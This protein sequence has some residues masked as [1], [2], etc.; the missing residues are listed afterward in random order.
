MA[1]FYSQSHYLVMFSFIYLVN[2]VD[3]LLVH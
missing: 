3:K 1:G 2:I